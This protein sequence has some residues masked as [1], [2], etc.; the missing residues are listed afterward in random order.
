MLLI[1]IVDAVQLMGKRGSYYSAFMVLG[2]WIQ[3]NGME[4]WNGMVW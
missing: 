3:W 4:W 2:I 1:A